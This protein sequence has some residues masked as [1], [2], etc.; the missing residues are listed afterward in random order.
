MPPAAAAWSRVIVEQ[1]HASRGIELHAVQH[2]AEDL[3]TRQRAAVVVRA[4]NPLRVGAGLDA[5][6]R[7]L[8][9]ARRDVR[10]VERSGVGQERQIDVRGDVAA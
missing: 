7:D 9:A 5:A 4:R 6:P 8:E 10:E 1:R 3:H 2:R